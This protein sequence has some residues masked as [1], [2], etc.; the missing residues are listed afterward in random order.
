[1]SATKRIIAAAALLLAAAPIC[2]ATAARFSTREVV[3]ET[4]SRT[5]AFNGGMVYLS[6]ASAAMYSPNATLVSMDVKQGDSVNAGDVVGVYS[7]E[8]SRADV[9][10]AENALNNASEDYE[11]EKKRRMDEIEALNDMSAN[12]NDPDQS[13]IYQLQAMRA[14]LETEKYCREAEAQIASLENALANL[15]SSG[16]PQSILAPI[17][18]TV[19]ATASAGMT[20]AP[21]QTLVAMHDPAAALVAVSDP[22][23]ELRY[24]M[25][26]ELQLASHTGKAA[27][28]GVVVSCDSVLP[29]S[30]RTGTAYIAYDTSDRGSAYSG[31]S[32]AAET[33]R[34]ENALIAS[35]KA[36]SYNNGRCR[37]QILDADG[38]VRTRY[39]N[40]G[41]ETASD[42]W[43]IS[44]IS[45]GDKLITK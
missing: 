13:R 9:V 5:S 38:T 39:V 23:G 7:I 17:T 12:E 26:V 20:I 6:T 8:V 25:P 35:P 2:L 45:E 14:Q 11:Y 22:E 43:I 27:C 21:G 19:D 30:L 36:I 16:E 42:V 29:A 41:F 24:G 32:V 40:K 1:M 37:V 4:F 44:G 15:I 28:Q 34:V 31:A 3:T 18:G 33:L 10:R